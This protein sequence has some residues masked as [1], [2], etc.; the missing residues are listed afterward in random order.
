[1]I[2]SEIQRTTHSK[3]RDDNKYPFHRM[4]PWDLVFVELESTDADFATAY[5]R[6]RAYAV[7]YGKRNNAKF[8]MKAMNKTRIAIWRIE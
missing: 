2:T 5:G 6:L 8:S 7:W 3:V 4:H 1:M